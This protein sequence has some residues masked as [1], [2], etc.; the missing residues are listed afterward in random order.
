[1]AKL[2]VRDNMIERGKLEDMAQS[3]ERNRKIF[4]VLL[5][6]MASGGVAYSLGRYTGKCDSVEVPPAGVDGEESGDKQV[7]VI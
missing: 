5:N 4:R 6:L 3:K 7:Y 2:K 1:M